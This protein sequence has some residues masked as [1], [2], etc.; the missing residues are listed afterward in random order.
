MDSTHH[1]HI[2][3]VTQEV[4]RSAKYRSISPELIRAVAARELRAHPRVREAAKSTRSK[5]HQVVGS[6][7]DAGLDAAASVELLRAAFADAAGPPAQSPTVRAACLALM[8][9]HAS[10]RERLPI[11]ETFY[12]QVF[13]GLP[14]VRSLLDLACGLNPLAL[15]W[16]PLAQGATYLA[17][18]VHGELVDIVAAFLSLTG[19]DGRATVCDLAAAIPSVPADVAL[20]L[21]LLPVLEQLQR[22]AALRLLQD[23]AA[24][25]IVVSYPTRSL[26][27][28]GRGMAV[29]YERQ[30]R[31]LVAGQPWDITR[32]EFPGELV[33]LV[34]KPASR[35]PPP[36]ARA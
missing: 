9:R 1:E 27:G 3:A 28:R 4:L 20:A 15:G 29:T 35:P 25:R 19:V 13:A 5:L 11:L 2:E 32:F 18:D 30:L 22:G 12:Q 26:G 34:D 36:A 21:K 6:Y 23:T 10:T 24:G 33:F 8:R 31:E 7:V 14:P 17:C 16:M